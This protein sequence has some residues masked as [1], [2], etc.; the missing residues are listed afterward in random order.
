MMLSTAL[1]R[2]EEN[3]HKNK[4]IHDQGCLERIDGTS[5][6]EN[7]STVAQQHY[8]SFCRHTLSSLAQ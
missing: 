6:S 8:E 3:G 2:T 4:L 7:T 1:L 5:G